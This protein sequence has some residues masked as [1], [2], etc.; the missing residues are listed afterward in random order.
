M[1]LARHRRFHIPRR[2]QPKGECCR[3]AQRMAKWPAAGIPCGEVTVAEARLRARIAERWVDRIC[4][5]IIDLV[6][7]VSSADVE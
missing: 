5:Y 7:A 3:V 6:A 1:R 2:G 4:Q